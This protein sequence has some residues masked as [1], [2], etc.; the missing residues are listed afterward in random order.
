MKGQTGRQ[1]RD[2]QDDLNAFDRHR[3]STWLGLTCYLGSADGVE[4]LHGDTE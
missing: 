3:W 1:E 2:R 4:R